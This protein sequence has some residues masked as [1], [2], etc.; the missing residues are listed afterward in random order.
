MIKT[1]VKLYTQPGGGLSAQHRAPGS[2]IISA[3]LQTC[4]DAFCQLTL[5]HNGTVIYSDSIYDIAA[6]SQILEDIRVCDVCVCRGGLPS[7][8]K[9]DG[10][11][12]RCALLSR[13]LLDCNI[14]DGD[15]PC[16]CT[17]NA[18]DLFDLLQGSRPE[19]GYTLNNG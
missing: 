6:A 8:Y 12:Q 15:G 5:V 2:K 11:C 14:C 18:V 13:K 16:T 7:V 3:I 19:Y 1:D 10:A 4:P 17:K 9:S